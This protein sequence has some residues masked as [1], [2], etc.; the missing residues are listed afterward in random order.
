[1]TAFGLQLI[2][3]PACPCYP[4]HR[5]GLARSRL[6]SGSCNRGNC[7]QIRAE[8]GESSGDNKGGGVYCCSEQPSSLYKQ[9]PLVT[10]LELLLQ[11]ARMK[12]QKSCF[13]RSYR[14]GESRGLVGL[15]QLHHW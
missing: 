5:P 12:V 14:E 1:M 11:I 6:S 10:S 4:L 9:A 2:K 13:R 3:L 15:V 7:C 8:S